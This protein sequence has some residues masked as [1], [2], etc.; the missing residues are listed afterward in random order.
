MIFYSKTYD[1]SHYYY[2][3]HY[4]IINL[5]ASEVSFIPM[6]HLQKRPYIEIDL[7]VVLLVHFREACELKKLVLIFLFF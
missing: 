1:Y 2:W 7:S 5:V 3:H 6:A 4:F